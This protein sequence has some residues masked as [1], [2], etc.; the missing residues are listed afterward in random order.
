MAARDPD[1]QKKLIVIARRLFAKYGY[2]GT[3][4]S[5]IAAE[6][7]LSKAA[8]YHHFE[9]KEAI[10]RAISVGGMGLLYETVLHAVEEAG[11]TPRERLMAYMRASASH[12]ER[13]RDNWLVN[14]ALFWGKQVPSGREAV[15]SV[16]DA[17]ETL[18]KRL[19]QE[20]M[21][22]GQFRADLDV[23]LASKFLLSSMNQMPRWHHSDGEKSAVEVMEVFVDL[24]L[25]GVEASPNGVAPA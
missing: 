4:L 18:L 24:F 22:T 8:L 5:M 14:S 19:I 25:R 9:N 16:R 3:S 6:A 17:Y 2:R 1:R 10:Y 12:F 11:G 23:S 20:G 21:Q 7:G 15:I 13:N